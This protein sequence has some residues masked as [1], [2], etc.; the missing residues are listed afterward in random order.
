MDFLIQS[1]AWKITFA[2]ISDSPDAQTFTI[3]SLDIV[4]PCRPSPKELW[5]CTRVHITSDVGDW[6]PNL[7]ES[8]LAPIA[9]S[10]SSFTNLTAACSD[11]F[12]S[13]R[14]MGCVFSH[15]RV[16][17][18]DGDDDFASVSKMATSCKDRLT[19]EQLS[20]VWRI[21]LR[22]AKRTLKVSTHQCMRTIGV[23]TPRFRTDK[24]HM[25]F[26]QLSTRHGDFYADYLKCAVKSI[27]GFIGGTV[28][29]NK[30]GFKK[31]YPM[32]TEQG[33]ENSNTLRSFIQLIGIPRKL[34]T[35]N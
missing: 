8:T 22:T 17:Y 4:L 20:S 31:F 30:L 32:M 26:K 27:R 13:D 1:S 25:R 16:L 5:D 28:C 3:P 19:P 33:K 15:K 21:G 23:L 24:A 29:T 14:L 18:P 12:L 11:D 35:D 34:H 7:L 9:L 6:N 2:S 10:A